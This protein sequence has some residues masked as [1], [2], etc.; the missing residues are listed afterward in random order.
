MWKINNQFAKSLW[1]SR[2]VCVQLTLP[3]AHGD[4]L[5]FLRLIRGNQDCVLAGGDIHLWWVHIRVYTLLLGSEVTW[6]GRNT[7]AFMRLREV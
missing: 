1:T 6:T 4:V 7:E 5:L 3:E 2:S